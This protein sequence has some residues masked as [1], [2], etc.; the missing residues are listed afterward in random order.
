MSNIYHNNYNPDILSCLANLSNDEVFTPPEIANQMLDLL[1]QQIWSDSTATF[2]DPCCKSGVFLREI[3][4]RLL[5]G[6]EKEIPDLQ[7]RIDHIFHKQL[8]GISI[9]ELTSL[10]SRRSVYCSKYPN[11]K[12]S[13]SKFADASGNIR[14]KRLNHSWKNGKCEFCGAAASEYQRSQDLETHAYEWIHTLHPE[15]IFTMKFD[16]I[17]GNPP[18]QISDG[19]FGD[20][21]KP[22]YNLFVDKAKLLS[23]NYIVMIIPARWYAGGKGLD[24][25]RESM[26]IDKRIKILHDFPETSDCFP[27]LNIR[28]GI[29]FFLWDKNYNGKCTVINNK[30]NET[31]SILKR[32]LL[33]KN[34]TTFIRYNDAINILHKVQALKEETMD[35][36]V[37]SRKPFGLATNFKSYS[38]TP[39]SY[40]N[41]LL[42]RNGGTGYI[43]KVHIQKNL[44]LIGKIK[45]IVAKASPGSDDYP[46]LVFS[47]PII[48]PPNSVC[49]ETYLI[50]STLNSIKEAK[51]L[52]TYM[53]TKFFRFLVLLIK[54]TQDVP[55]RV[56][57]FVPKQDLSIEWTDDKLFKKYNITT[58]EV[59]FIN[60]LVKDVNWDGDE[61][62]N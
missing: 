18:Y 29:C 46:H 20:S 19:G 13:I 16:V 28:G 52:K 58:E 33:E 48:A 9:T 4:K 17:I 56:Y 43:N 39:D 34:S 57:S 40:N 45:L 11:S 55:R 60:T 24:T 41:I 59:A 53:S 31:V 22:I 7:Q 8:Y 37:S 54:N 26:L 1:P 25:F 61:H 12:Y 32:N 3:A 15:E 30:G 51:N 42:F 14:Y 38:D 2:L 35:S 62:G 27:G 6:L 44:D 36:L 50:V 10:L 49:T 21:A 23:P 47:E 5:I